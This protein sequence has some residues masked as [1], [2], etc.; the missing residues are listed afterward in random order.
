MYCLQVAGPVP[1]AI[2][3]YNPQGQLVSR[4]S[5]DEVNQVGG[6]SRA[7]LLNFRSYQQSQGGKYECRVTV[8]GNNLEEL[9][10]CIGEHY[11]DCRLMLWKLC[12]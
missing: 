4:S 7:A 8:S 11:T 3:W 9:P 2:E 12:I 10:V 6:G 5:E 1:T